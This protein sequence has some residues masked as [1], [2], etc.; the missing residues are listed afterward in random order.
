MFHSVL[1]TNI[2]IGTHFRFN[3][4]EGQRTNL[5]GLFGNAFCQYSYTQIGYYVVCTMYTNKITICDEQVVIGYCKWLSSVQICKLASL[6]S[7]KVE[8]CPHM[9]CGYLHGDCYS[10]TC[11]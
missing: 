8:I 5:T 11:G 9:I 1:S 6:F 3:K 4:F 2:L 10:V 7:I